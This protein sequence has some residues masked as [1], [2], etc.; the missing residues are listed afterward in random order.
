MLYLNS[1]R[2]GEQLVRSSIYIILVKY[3]LNELTFKIPIISL[4]R[5]LHHFEFSSQATIPRPLEFL[6]FLTFFLQ[7]SYL[8]TN[9]VSLCVL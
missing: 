5:V 2:I 4:V 1:H 9:I 6:I 3:D 7:F 8:T